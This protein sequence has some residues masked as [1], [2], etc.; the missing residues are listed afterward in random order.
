MFGFKAND[1]V[2]LKHQNKEA[3]IIRNFVAST[4]YLVRTDDGKEFAVDRN[5]IIKI[6]K[7]RGW[8]NV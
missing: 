3:T 7:N 4:S 5:D 8:H 6:D 2:I 1:R